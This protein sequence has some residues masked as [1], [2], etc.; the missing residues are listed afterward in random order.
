MRRFLTAKKWDGLNLVSVK[1]KN[2]YSVRGL[3]QSGHESDHSL[4]WENCSAWHSLQH[5][6]SICDKVLW[7]L[8]HLLLLGLLL[9]HLLLDG[10][11]SLLL[12]SHGRLLLNHHVRLDLRLRLRLLL[13]H[14]SVGW[15]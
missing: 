12:R 3:N 5:V 4:C 11:H 14:T 7:D 15:L 6:I 10:S 2:V 13:N 1:W 8:G 9:L